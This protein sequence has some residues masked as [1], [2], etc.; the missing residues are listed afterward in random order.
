MANEKRKT[1]YIRQSVKTLEAMATKIE[2]IESAHKRKDLL[3]KVCSPTK[4][5][6]NRLA[7]HV[8]KSFKLHR[9]TVLRTK[10]GRRNQ[11]KRISELTLRVLMFLQDPQWSVTYPGKKDLISC[12][13]TMTDDN[14]KQH[15]WRKHIPKVVLTENLK[16]LHRIY[17]EQNP[18]YR[19]NEKF[20]KGVRRRSQFIKC[21]NHA[22]A[23]VC[24]CQKH[25]NFA[26]KLRAIA[27]HTRLPQ[28]PDTLFRKFDLAEF[29]KTLNEKKKNLPANIFFEEWKYTFI[30]ISADPKVAFD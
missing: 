4:I 27:P 8:S 6:A 15:V 13:Y 9:K 14:G 23:D 25:Q 17:N 1:R 20:F 19:V 24:L 16:E 3:D 7:S 12:R 29:E 5:R 18:G 30:P 22:K 26:L 10:T 28:V 11:K 2:R 21:L